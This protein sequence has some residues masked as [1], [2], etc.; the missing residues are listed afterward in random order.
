[1]SEGD[2]EGRRAGSTRNG[3]DQKTKQREQKENP[4]DKRTEC[5]D[6]RPKTHRL[7]KRGK[8]TDPAPAGKFGTENLDSSDVNWPQPNRQHEHGEGKNAGN[9]SAKIDIH[10]RIR[11]DE[12]RGQLRAE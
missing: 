6:A 11:F 4:I 12:C 9:Q 3:R 8:K 1:E 7:I 2:R 5:G 10:V